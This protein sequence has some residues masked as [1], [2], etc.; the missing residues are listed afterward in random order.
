MRALTEEAPGAWWVPGTGLSLDCGDG[1][2]DMTLSLDLNLLTYTRVPWTVLEAC[3][4]YSRGISDVVTA[5]QFCL[6]WARGSG[7][8]QDD[9]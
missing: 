7:K 5:S 6:G 3:T 1:D 2:G 8:P 9:V 4:R